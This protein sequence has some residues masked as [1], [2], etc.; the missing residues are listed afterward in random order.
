MWGDASRCGEMWGVVGI[1]EQMWG[2][3]GRCALMYRIA[4]S[5]YGLA[6]VS[7][8]PAPAAR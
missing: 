4:L 5:A 2:D 6:K 3:V 7:N 1:G 8:W